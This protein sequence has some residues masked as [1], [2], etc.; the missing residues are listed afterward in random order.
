MGL[1]AVLVAAVQVVPRQS[2]LALLRL[3]M[4]PE[5]EV[6]HQPYLVGQPK[7]VEKAAMVSSSSSIRSPD[8]GR[9]I[10]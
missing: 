8:R 6:P 7:Q 2:M 9:V 3:D 4:V 10:S 1:P 5:V